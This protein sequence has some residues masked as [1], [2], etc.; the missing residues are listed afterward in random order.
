MALKRIAPGLS[1]T[2][3][4]TTVPN[5]YADVDLKYYP[6]RGTMFEDGQRRGDVFKKMDIKS[7]DQSIQ[8]ILLTNHYE[9]PF[10]PLFGANLRRLLFELNTLISQDDVE[11]TVRRALQRDEP[12]VEVLSVDIHDLG[13]D[14][15]IPKGA[16]NVFFYAVQNGTSRYAMLVNV[17]CRIKATGQ[18]IKTSVNMNRLR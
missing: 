8:N 2:T 13:E 17:H 6:K 15:Q 10:D 14:K 16:S 18:E 7:I 12:R 11:E 5:N 4:V 3:L 1:D 9:K